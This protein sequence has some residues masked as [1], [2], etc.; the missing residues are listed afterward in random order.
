[1]IQVLAIYIVDANPGLDHGIM[2]DND[3]R[4]EAMG[5]ASPLMTSAGCMDKLCGG[6]SSII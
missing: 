2:H 3:I 4:G 1:M 5:T 6:K